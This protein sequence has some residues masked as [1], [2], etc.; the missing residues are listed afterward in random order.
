MII[1]VNTMDF[2]QNF[3][4]TIVAPRGSGKSFL[5]RLWLHEYNHMYDHIFILCPSIK[6]N[7][8]YMDFKDMTHV[9]LMEP[10]IVEL[11]NIID[12]QQELK[13]I[14]KLHER[15]G[16][17]PVQCPKTLVVM[18]DCIDSNIMNFR[19]PADQV[20]ERG[21]HFDISIIIDAQRLSSVSR[22]IRINSTWFLFFAPYSVN[23]F[24]KFMEQFMPR[25]LRKEI[26]TLLHEAYG[27]EH[28]FVVVDNEERQWQLKLKKSIAQD[29]VRKKV[30]LI[31]PEHVNHE[32]LHEH[33]RSSAST[34][35]AKNKSE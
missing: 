12:A 11:H 8:D 20:A 19:G 21:R 6:F 16:G 28:V 4:M 22:S 18:D 25:H 7:D 15:Q 34:Q 33:L 5:T 32:C 35:E 23:E 17:H 3:V 9:H 13:K 1:S 24:D 27:E 26:R 29:F 2:E 30:E 14:E 10:S 31:I